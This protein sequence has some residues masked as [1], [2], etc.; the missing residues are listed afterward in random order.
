MDHR[1][2]YK[3]TILLTWVFSKSLHAY[4]FSSY[5]IHKLLVVVLHT[6]PSTA[7]QHISCAFFSLIFFLFFRDGSK[8]IWVLSKLVTCWLNLSVFHFKI[9]FRHLQDTENKRFILNL[10]IDTQLGVSCKEETKLSLADR[11]CWTNQNLRE[12]PLQ[13]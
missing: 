8:E 13:A 4:A 9:H 10:Y 7:F 6:D 1:A 2:E 3:A 12:E 11:V 5:Y